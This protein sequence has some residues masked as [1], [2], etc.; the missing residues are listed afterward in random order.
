MKKLLFAF[1]AVTIMFG[2]YSCGGTAK[3]VVQSPTVPTP[4]TIPSNNPFGGETY[5]MPTFE[6]DTEEYFAASGIATGPR[7]RMNILQ[8]N[9]L[10]NAQSM[11]RQKM[12]H[13]YE[14]M[15][16]EYASSIGINNKSDI[17]DKIERA[18]NQISVKFI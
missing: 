18:G 2:L 12:Q 16:S 7:Q 5:T 8:Q 14:G 9:A 4:Q 17:A 10:T 3:T 1:A 11:I 13:A 6:P 15:V